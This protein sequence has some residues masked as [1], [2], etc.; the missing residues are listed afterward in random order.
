MRAP[1]VLLG[2]RNI[3]R[4]LASS[5]ATW[6]IVALTVMVAVAGVSI[7]RVIGAGLAMASDR[8]G[9]DI[10]V[11]PSEVGV[12]AQEALFVAEPANVYMPANTVDIVASVEGVARVTPQFFTQTLNQS[13]CS[14]MGVTRVVGIDPA[15]DFVITPWLAPGSGELGGDG[16]FIGAAAPVP[17]GDMVSILGKQF[18]VDGNLEATGTSVDETVFMDIDSARTIGWESPYLGNVWKTADPFTSVSAVMVSVADGYDPE[19]VARAIDEACPVSSATAVSGLVRNTGE[20]LDLFAAMF[21]GVLAAVVLIAALGLAG[22][23]SAVAR[24]RRRE[25]GY[26][27]AIG[28][29]RRFVAGALLSEVSML[30]LAGSVAGGV[31]G[32]VIAS[33]AAPVVHRVMALPAV[34]LSAVEAVGLVLVASAAAVAVCAAAALVP[35]RGVLK[36]GAYGAMQKG[37]LS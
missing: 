29:S 26:L 23:L 32:C 37:D 14:T 5:A 35:A 30:A 18:F 24:E 11:L 25:M 21:V 31:A 34:G 7:N 17:V 10:I 19:E 4:R 28:F 3:Q 16:I 6:A 2:W 33:L 8:L 15:S 22:R 12:S 9:A 36:D 27:R 1:A 13:C 20:Q